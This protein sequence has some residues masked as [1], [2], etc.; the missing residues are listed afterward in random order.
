M[1]PKNP[2]LISVQPRTKARVT[3]ESWIVS[4]QWVTRITLPPLRKTLAHN[5]LCRLFTAWKG[6]EEKEKKAK[7]RV[8]GGNTRANAPITGDHLS[9]CSRCAELQW[10]RRSALL[11]SSRS[12]KG[13]HWSWQQWAGRVFAVIS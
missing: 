8:D 4:W 11:Y 9:E 3:A 5:R 1:N 12:G 13:P 7:T 10:P 6:E 2:P